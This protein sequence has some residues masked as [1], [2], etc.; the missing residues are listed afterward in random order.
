M[1]LQNVGQIASVTVPD[2]WTKEEIAFHGG[3]GTPRCIEFQGDDQFKVSF[4]YRGLPIDQGSANTLSD[5]LQRKRAFAGPEELT[6]EEIVSLTM[7]FGLSTVGDNQYCNPTPPGSDGEPAFRMDRAETLSL[8]NRTVLFVKGAFR[9]GKCFCGIYAQ[10]GEHNTV[11]EEV[12]LESE[13]SGNFL[14]YELRFQSVLAS[15]KWTDINFSP[16]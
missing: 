11:I 14:E 6:A 12:F 8:N 7:V 5:L 13:D 16:A 15:I 4:F 9:L 3:M 2:N 10:S 1:E